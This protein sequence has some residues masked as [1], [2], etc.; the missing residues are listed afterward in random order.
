MAVRTGRPLVPPDKVK[1]SANRILLG[2]PGF[3]QLGPVFEVVNEPVTLTLYG[4]NMGQTVGVFSVF[5]PYTA[6]QVAEYRID[7]NP[8]VLSP[9][10][11]SVSINVSG[12]YRLVLYGPAGPSVVS[13]KNA[14]DGSAVI[15]APSGAQANRPNIFLDGGTES[16]VI[17]I[18]DKAWVFRA[19]GLQPTD[20]IDVYSTYGTGQ[21][22]REERLFKD[23]NAVYISDLNNSVSLE[24]SGRYIFKLVGDPAGVTLVGNPTQL[25]SEGTSSGQPGPPG[26]GVPP[27]GNAGQLLAKL[28]D[29]SFSTTWIDPPSGVGTVTFV[30]VTGTDGIE[31]DSGSPIT[32][33]GTIQLGLSASTLA[34][35]AAAS[36]AL[37]PGQADPPGAAAA[38]QAAAIAYTDA[39]LADYT[40][41][42]GL[43]S[44]AFQPSTAFAT[45]AQ[46]GLAASALQPG[47]SID[48]A[49]LINIPANI[50]AWEAITPSE[51]ENAGAA[52]A[53]FLGA[54]EYAT[55][56]FS[57]ITPETLGMAAGYNLTTGARLTNINTVFGSPP[58]FF[59]CASG[60]TGLPID[61]SGQGVYVPFSST[62]G[63]MIYTS[64]SA[65]DINRR[66]FFRAGS[67]STWTSWIEFGFRYWN[68]TSAASG[69]TTPNLDLNDA[70]IRTALAANLTIN[71]PSGTKR[72]GRIIYF[73]FKDDG[74]ARTLTWG[75]QYRASAT[76]ALPTTTTIGKTLYVAFVVNEDETT[77]DIIQVREMV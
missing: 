1:P 34:A 3:E 14:V 28:T 58:M 60:A 33:T 61:V 53:A 2:S 7:G 41:T 22:Y 17:E 19:Y 69:N 27:G 50:A 9:S 15:P 71:N 18:A 42:S 6:L 8:V 64:S 70:V 73:R 21:A 4:A 59:S 76:L 38:A 37:Q 35:L 45:A 52:N 54:T 23:G 25:D 77:L 29:T 68:A 47:S 43:G 10:K 57:G 74:T 16:P 39:E 24:R 63:M 31:V 32:S 5:G 46:G 65:Q 55:A 75:S 11:T 62:A 49:W 66:F 40:P 13:V 12:R 44:A 36:T 30:A 26:Q 20:Y 56:L 72:N 67:G 48:W 51:K